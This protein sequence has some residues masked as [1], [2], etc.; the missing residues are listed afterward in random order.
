[1]VLAMLRA[2]CLLG[3]RL[4]RPGGLLGSCH[5]AGGCP[6]RGRGAEAA[7]GHP[8]P[9]EGSGSPPKPPPSRRGWQRG[10]RASPW[11]WTRVHPGLDYAH[12]Q[13]ADG[14]KAPGTPV[15]RCQPAPC[16]QGWAVVSPPPSLGAPQPPKVP[17]ALPPHC[18][19]MPLDGV[20]SKMWGPGGGPWPAGR[21][22]QAVGPH[23]GVSGMD[24]G[25][26]G[27][28]MG[29]TTK[30]TE[31][32]CNRA[33]GTGSRA[34]GRGTHRNGR[35][36][37][38]RSPQ[39][40]PRP[41]PTAITTRSTPCAGTPAPPHGSGFK[42]HRPGPALPR[43]PRVRPSASSPRAQNRAGFA[44]S[45]LSPPFPPSPPLYVCTK[46]VILPGLRTVLKIKIKP[47]SE[48]SRGAASAGSTSCAPPPRWPPAASGGLRGGG[49]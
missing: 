33:M 38:G 44:V 46:D 26:A 42:C 32:G 31:K 48:G 13:G 49:R 25:G 12:K 15:S 35:K 18:P 8:A 19:L 37:G 16:T 28:P 43:P 6:G 7:L 40:H 1:M 27:A 17:P 41:P 4:A 11:P 20:P 36:Q 22:E 5:Q 3:S 2:G 45:L 30:S 21:G 47:V 34:I 39:G 23:G 14:P 24:T 9:R 29:S 10:A